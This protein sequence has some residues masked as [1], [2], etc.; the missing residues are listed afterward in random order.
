M[1]F[2]NIA[3][4][5]VAMYDVV[6]DEEL[7][8][9]QHLIAVIIGNK[10]ATPEL[11]G[12][13]AQGGAR[14]LVD[15]T[16]QE[17]ELVGLTHQE[18][19]K[20]HSSVILAKKLSKVSVEAST[21]IRSPDDIFEYVSPK[22]KDVKQEHLMAIFLDSKLKVI[23]NSTIFIGSLASCIVHP[24]EIFREAVKCSASSFVCAHQHPSGDPL[25]IV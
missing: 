4:E 8:E 1:N 17:L 18:A 25:T 6:G 16:V 12:R 11:T 19:L 21:T 13:L 3:R 14:A 23:K 2:L 5:S 7:V 9:L 15:M 20:L 24:R 22:I 10:K